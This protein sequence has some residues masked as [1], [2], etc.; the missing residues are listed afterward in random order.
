MNRPA[1]MLAVIAGAL[2]LAVYLVTF[3]RALPGP[4]SGELI[5]AACTLGIAHPPGYPLYTMFAHL[6][7][8]LVPI[9]GLPARLNLMSALLSAAAV[10]FAAA[11]VARLTARPFAGFVAALALAFSRPFWRAALV[12]EAFPL[13][14]LMAALLLFAFATL[15]D[16]A[17]LLAVARE[18][19]SPTSPRRPWPL[20]ILVL[21]TA[22]IPAHHHSLL[23]LALPLGAVAVA[24][25]LV[26]RTYALR[27]VHTLW[28]VGLAALG[29]APLLHLPLA[30]ARGAALSWGHPETLRGFIDLLT[31][32]DYGTFEMASGQTA[33]AAAANDHAALYVAAIPY[34]F[35]WPAAVLALIGALAL[36]ARAIRGRERAG[37]VAL[38]A[39]LLGF[40]LLQAL[41]FSRIH[42][43]TDSAYYRGVVE[44]FYVLP[45][46]AVAVLA[47]LGAAAILVRLPA[48]V[49]TAAG[50]ALAIL[51]AAP[52]LVAHGPTLDQRGNRFNE[53]LARNVLAS[54]P[55]DAVLFSVGDV[56]Y[57][58]ITYLTLCEG[59]R[60]DV[61]FVDQYL[62]TRPW[63]VAAMR[64]RHPDVLPPFDRYTGEGVT[65]SRHWIE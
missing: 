23:M 1:W 28:A 24:L 9:D 4:D 60:P 21:V 45:D 61:V 27:P 36:A 18:P 8:A 20:A 15:L 12:A 29:L 33:A 44:R 6:F 10:A 32:A 58:G 41:F 48:R 43:A 42:L 16:D 25:A 38:G 59:E 30:G 50:I 34:G 11:T 65:V 55:P 17:G 57:D 46:L 49:S 37:A 64:R 26:R 52:P 13:N 54:L 51:A 14:T 47:G 2:A 19:R 53:D 5:A 22:M 7:G 39:V 56:V 63:Y 35:G 3:H 62:L 40:A 31:R